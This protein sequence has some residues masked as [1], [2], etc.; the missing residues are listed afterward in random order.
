MEEVE[1]FYDFD[2]NVEGHQGSGSI[3][4]RYPQIEFQLIIE[5]NHLTNKDTVDISF[6]S[7]NQSG[8]KSKTYPD[9]PYNQIVARTVCFIIF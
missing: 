7:A 1:I 5:R 8:L 3:L 6:Y 9:T 2:V 4:L